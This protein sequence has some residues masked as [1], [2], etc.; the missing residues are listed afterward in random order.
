MKRAHHSYKP[1]IASEFTESQDDGE[2][3]DYMST[4]FLPTASSKPTTYTQQRLK[5][6]KESEEKGRIISPKITEV[7]RRE[8]GLATAIGS[9]NKGFRMLQKMGFK[10][11]DEDKTPI[12][13]VL[14]SSID[15]MI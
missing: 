1:K 8:E 3:E 5:K 14:K 10:P 6:L 4:T 2:E 13:V 7:E 15:S 12:T 11:D 9:E